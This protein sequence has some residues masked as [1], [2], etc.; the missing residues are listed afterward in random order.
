M[1]DAH[2]GRDVATADIVGAY[3]HAYMKD[4]VLLKITG[5]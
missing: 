1:V 4:F 3:I 5:Q 2:E